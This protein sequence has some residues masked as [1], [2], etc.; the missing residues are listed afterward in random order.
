MHALLTQYRQTPRHS[1]PGTRSLSITKNC[2]YSWLLSRR[3]PHNLP[4]AC[5]RVSIL[6]CGFQRAQNSCQAPDPVK[7]SPKSSL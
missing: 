1:H 4:W 3:V 7:N 5:R 2:M 6:R